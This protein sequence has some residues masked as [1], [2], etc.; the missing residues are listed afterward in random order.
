MDPPI[1]FLRAHNRSKPIIAIMEIMS[2]ALI[3]LPG[4]TKHFI[5]I[6]RFEN[7][8]TLF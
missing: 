5:K 1:D 6:L 3:V 8:C 2:A 7:T 4:K